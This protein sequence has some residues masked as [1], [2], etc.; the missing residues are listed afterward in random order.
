MVVLLCAI[1]PG[2]GCGDICIVYL[3]TIYLL[4]FVNIYIIYS[5]LFQVP[6]FIPPGKGGGGVGWKVTNGGL[7]LEVDVAPGGGGGRFTFQ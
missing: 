1:S 4:W 5:A 7:G 2:K 6:E 3:Y